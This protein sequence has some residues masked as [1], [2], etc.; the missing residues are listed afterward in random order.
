MTPEERVAYTQKMRAEAVEQLGAWAE[1]HRALQRE[2][3][4]A[5]HERNRAIW[6]AKELGVPATT[7]AAE[8]GLTRDG[9]YKA[10]DKLRGTHPVKHPE[11]WNND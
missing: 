2:L 3:E 4:Q 9:V 6:V 5:E 8:V 11:N 7:I 1:Q 10:L